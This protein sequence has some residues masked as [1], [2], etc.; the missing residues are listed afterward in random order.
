VDTAPWKELLSKLAYEAARRGD[1]AQL[2]QLHILACRLMAQ[3]DP[4]PASQRAGLELID[5]P[6]AALQVFTP[7][8]LSAAEQEAL[9]LLRGKED[10]FAAQLKHR[11]FQNPAFWSSPQQQ[12]QYWPRQLLSGGDA[13]LLGL[14]DYE[15]RQAQ[16]DQANYAQI[17]APAWADLASFDYPTLSFPAAN[18]QLR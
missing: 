8:P 13:A 18:A 1:R 4:S 7:R 10:Q 3:L 17:D 2:Q 15:C 9:S 16:T 14:L 6:A 5:I 12:A 11:S